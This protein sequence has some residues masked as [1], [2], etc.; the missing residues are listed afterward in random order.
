MRSTSSLRPCRR[1][2]SAADRHAGEPPKPTETAE[3]RSCYALEEEDKEEE[4]GEGEEGEK[5]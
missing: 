5:G 1:G 3:V 4:E 2:P